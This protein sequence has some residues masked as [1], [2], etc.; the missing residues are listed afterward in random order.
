MAE[1]HFTVDEANARLEHLREVLPRIRDARRVLLAS[2]ERV[3]GAAARNGGG[4]EGA[5][6][7]TAVRTLRDEVQALG[8]EGIVLRDAESGLVDFPAL[9]EGREV[10]L[11]WRLGEDAVAHWHDVDGGFVGRRP[12]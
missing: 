8:D 10:Y 4:S 5:A 2:G 11:C 3:R 12:I 1:R 9:R 7:W 6:Y